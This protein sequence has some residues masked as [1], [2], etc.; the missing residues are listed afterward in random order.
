MLT[1]YFSGTG[2]T[3]YIAE[4]LSERMGAQCVSI[5]ADFAFDA[6]IAT[7]DLIAVCYPIYGSRVPLIMRRFVN[8]HMEAFR[9]KRIII[10][11]TQVT[12]SGNGARAFLDLLPTDHVEVLY[13][14]HLPMPNNVCNL[15][16][17]YRKPS[18]VQNKKQ[19]RRGIGRLER[20]CADLEAGRVKR[21]GFSRV[22][23]FFG[24]LQ[25]A[26]WQDRGE[27]L[28]GQN[29]KIH[30][31]CTVC[32]LCVSLCPMRNLKPVLKLP[33]YTRGY[34]RNTRCASSICGGKRDTSPP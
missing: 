12:F 20:V 29:L 4:R 8:R 9:G 14:E 30:S 2:N 31:D 15:W 33:V 10:L 17:L 22:S 1:L 5:E 26:A 24:N 3:K 16:P 6:A 13:A 34:S 19:I 28:M 21:R 27:R 23:Q 25:G 18:D 11:V 7:A 32:G